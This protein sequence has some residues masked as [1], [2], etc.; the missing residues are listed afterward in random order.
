MGISRYRSLEDTPY[1]FTGAAGKVQRVNAGATALENERV[2]VAHVKI[3]TDATTIAVDASL[4]DLFTVILGGNRTMGAPTNPVNGQKI[5]FKIEQDGTG[6]RTLSWNAIFRF[7]T[8][9]PAPTITTASGD[10]DYVGF[11]YNSTDTKWDCI[12]LVQGFAS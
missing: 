9:I 4:G 2:G 12:A 10:Y 6:S 1:N 7:S 3:L 11:I 8:D 5:M